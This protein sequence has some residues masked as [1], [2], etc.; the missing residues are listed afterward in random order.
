MSLLANMLF[1][2]QWRGL[3]SFRETSAIMYAQKRNP[4]ESASRG[5]YVIPINALSFVLYLMELIAFSNQ[6][7]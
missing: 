5:F 6:G 7:L 2:G 1:L 4:L 3:E